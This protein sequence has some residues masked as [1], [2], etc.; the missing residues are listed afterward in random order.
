MERLVVPSKTDLELRNML[1][2]MMDGASGVPIVLDQAPTS[3]NQLL[4]EGQRGIF[5]SDLYETVN[6]TTFKYGTAV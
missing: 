1:H 5:G 3:A 4:K 2:S 6:G